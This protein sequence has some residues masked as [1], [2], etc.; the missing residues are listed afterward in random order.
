MMLYEHNHHKT[1]PLCE[2]N[3]DEIARLRAEVE[4]EPTREWY[5]TRCQ[6]YQQQLAKAEVV[7]RAAEGVYSMAIPFARGVNILQE[8]PILSGNLAKSI[9]TFKRE[10]AAYRGRMPR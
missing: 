1:C 7:V 10:I 5:E 4:R 3:D 8:Y 6:W 2:W 9:E